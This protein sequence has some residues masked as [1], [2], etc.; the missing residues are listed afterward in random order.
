[1]FTRN[2]SN[3]ANQR[4]GFHDAHVRLLA[5]DQEIIDHISSDLTFVAPVIRQSHLM[6]RAT[7]PIGTLLSGTLA[8][9]FGGPAAV[10]MMSLAG[11]GVILLVIARHPAFVR[12]KVDLEET[13][14]V[15]VVV[16][17]G[18]L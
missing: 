13:P 9:Y 3:V 15:S 14:D 5:D 2:R 6:N 4:L 10:R 18:H 12:L 7:I 11:V 17:E 16:S 8:H 1:M